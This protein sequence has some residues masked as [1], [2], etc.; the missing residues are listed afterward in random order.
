[1]GLASI[2]LYPLL[3]LLAIV[4]IVLGA[5]ALRREVTPRWPAAIG[6]ITGSLG[7]LGELGHIMNQS[8]V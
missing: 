1:M 5:M 8:G 6:L 2:V 7:T 4:P 3:G